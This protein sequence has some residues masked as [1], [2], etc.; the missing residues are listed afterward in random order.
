VQHISTRQ[1]VS[2]DSES[3]ADGDAVQVVTFWLPRTGNRLVAEVYGM[4]FVSPIF[5]APA[6]KRAL[7]LRT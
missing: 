4:F 3:K 5:G 6:D 7:V 2:S 1:P